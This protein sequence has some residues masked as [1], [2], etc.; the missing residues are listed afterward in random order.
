MNFDAGSLW[1]RATDLL[2]SRV[3]PQLFNLWFAPLKPHSLTADTLTLAT[4]N[5]FYVDW[6]QE[7]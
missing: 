1:Q 7:N 6:I 4:P 5:D 3:S 2:R